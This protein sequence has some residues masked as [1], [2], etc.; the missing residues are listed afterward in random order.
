MSRCVETWSERRVVLTRSNKKCCQKPNAGSLFHHEG[1]TGGEEALERR[2]R[3]SALSHSPARTRAARRRRT[4]RA[5]AAPGRTAPRPARASAAAGSAA[6]SAAACPLAAR[7]RRLQHR[8]PAA[9]TAIAAD[10][11]TGVRTSMHARGPS[12][13]P[14]TGSLSR[15]AAWWASTIDTATVAVSSRTFSLDDVAVVFT[16]G[17]IFSGCS[18]TTT[19][20]VIK[21][22]P[23]P[24][25]VV[26]HNKAFQ[27]FLLWPSRLCWW[28]LVGK[29]TGGASF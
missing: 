11:A 13:M 2:A 22:K 15:R 12:S 8:P 10:A 28:V 18:T 25:T 16:Q 14:P 9:R 27:S 17:I 4:A 23:P 20:S 29:L 3:A 6:A 24:R 1:G 21:R 26:I 5:R 19:S 7:R